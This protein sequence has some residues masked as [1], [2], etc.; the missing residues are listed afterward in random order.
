MI[1]LVTIM[2]DSKSQV[3]KAKAQNAKMQTVVEYY[4]G[5]TV[6][7]GT[8]ALLEWG[9]DDHIRLFEIDHETK[10]SKGL[11]FDITPSQIARANGTVTNL[12]IKT[13]DGHRYT[14]E[15]SSTAMPWLMGGG[16]A[17]LYMA[18][19]DAGKSGIDWWMDNLKNNGVRAGFFSTSKA[20][21]LFFII[22]G[23]VFAALIII[24]LLIATFAL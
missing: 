7:S 2:A 12:Q 16:V 5:I 1:N 10:Q 21:K 23:L 17:G 6:F 19:N 14:M 18:D 8:L 3:T 15:L 24:L 22:G 13:T 20:I 9:A 4:K 11:V